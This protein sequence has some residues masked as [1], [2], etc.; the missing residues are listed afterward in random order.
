MIEVEETYLP[1]RTAG[2]KTVKCPY[3]GHG[4]IFYYTS[5]LHCSRC[6]CELPDIMGMLEGVKTDEKKLEYHRTGRYKSSKRPDW[7]KGEYD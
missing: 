3:C 4:E 6:S 5:P 2:R 7:L 1:L